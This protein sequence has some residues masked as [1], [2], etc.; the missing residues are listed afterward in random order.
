M[1]AMVAM[2]AGI[3]RLASSPAVEGHHDL[4]VRLVRWVRRTYPGDAEPVYVAE[5]TAL[6]LAAGVLVEVDLALDDVDRLMA[7]V[8][9]I[10]DNM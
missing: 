6:G 8:L 10:T 1:E 5:F 3:D 4:A 9:A 7:E 2:V